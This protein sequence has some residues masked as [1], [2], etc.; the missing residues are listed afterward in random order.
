MKYSNG[1]FVISYH[2]NIIHFSKNLVIF[3][4]LCIP[5]FS[6]IISVQ[7]LIE[8]P[9]CT[10]TFSLKEMSNSRQQFIQ[11]YWTS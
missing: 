10:L 7:R 11:N 8:D 6:F 2:A 4:V 3:N 1:S 9:N 5:K